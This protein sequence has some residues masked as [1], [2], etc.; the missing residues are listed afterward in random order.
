MLNEEL[1]CYNKYFLPT[2]H[3]EESVFLYR[4]GLDFVRDLS[5]I[6]NK[7]ILDIGGF[8]GDSILILSELTDDKVY[9]FEATSQNY[10]LMLKTIELNGIQNAVPVHSAVGSESGTLEIRFNGSA[11]SVDEIMVKNPDH[12]ETCN[13]IRIDDYVEEHG[14]NV[15]L[16]KVDIEG[17][18]QDFLKG[19]LG[20]IRKYKPVLL[21]SIYHNVSDFLDIK[22][23]IEDLELG[24]TFDVFKPV[25]GSVSGET[26]LICQTAD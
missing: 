1:F 11:S 19:A 15:G 16:I 18:E 3:F 20:T 5:R 4:H 25:N 26:L 12:I 8:I 23:L 6:K 24:Y 7:A 10:A 14:I 21:L 22:P 2:K 17:A 13:V 9:S